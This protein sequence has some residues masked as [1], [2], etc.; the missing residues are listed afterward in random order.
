MTLQ[1]SKV[2][3]NANATSKQTATSVWG[4]QQ[5]GMERFYSSRQVDGNLISV[6][7]TPHNIACLLLNLVIIPCLKLIQVLKLL[8]FG[9]KIYTIKCDSYQTAYTRQYLHSVA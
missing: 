2:A 5:D 1:N 3:F 8:H 7:L 9:V 4:W 6:N